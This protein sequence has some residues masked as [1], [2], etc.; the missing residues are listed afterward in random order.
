MK[1]Y[2]FDEMIDR[3][4]TYSAKF[5][6]L[7]M[8][9][10]RKDL[11]PMWIADMDFKTA[12]EIIESLKSRIEEGI[13]GYTSRPDE[14]FEAVRNWQIY[15]NGWSP[16][17]KYMSHALGVLPMLA[18]LCASVLEEGKSKVI[19]QTPV[20]S[21][22]KTVLDNW[23]M[24]IIYNPLKRNGTD[25]EIDFDDL[26][27]KSKEADFIIFCNPHN[28]IGKV[29]KKEDVQR[30]AEICVKNDVMI[31]SDEM[32]SDIM[33]WGNKHTPTA[34]ISEEIRQR[35]IT[36]TS[37][38]KT[39][40]LAGVQVATCIFPNEELKAK[41]E[42]ILAKFETKRNNAFSV[43]ANQVAMN[44]GKEWFEEVTK[45]LEDNIEFAMNYISK[46]IPQIKFTKPEGTY[47]LWLDCRGLKLTQEELVSFFVNDA[48]IALNDG[49]TF[50]EE[51]RGYM[52]MNM[53][54]PRE[55]IVTAL[56]QLEQAV[57]KLNNDKYDRIMGC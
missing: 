24:E 17:T 5:D 31:I 30:M 25:Y 40:N 54:S 39:F 27:V 47:L 41:Y 26:E 7:E 21:E 45:Y 6:E 8:K 13:W 1:K 44:E 19:L 16:E 9:F 57:N 34:S 2:N 53:A 14:Y 48:R 18:N 10:G 38:G 32:Y 46:N 51:G 28:P 56:T 20:F 50:G 15:K 12:P 52:R 33:L 42:K 35:T 55:V 43:V 36:C 3:T 11:I 29:W 23:G 22:F 37:L 4:N 49:I